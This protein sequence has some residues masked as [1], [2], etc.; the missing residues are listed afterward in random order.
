MTIQ[1]CVYA[2]DDL[3]VIGMD[4]IM[5]IDNNSDSKKYAF[6]IPGNENIYN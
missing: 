1:I 4:S 6:S 5:N 2:C 3:M